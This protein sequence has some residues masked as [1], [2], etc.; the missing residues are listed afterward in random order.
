MPPVGAYVSA[1]SVSS[2]RRTSGSSVSQLRIH[3]RHHSH[4]SFT[5]AD[6]ST[7]AGSAT[8]D[9]YQVMTNGTS[10]PGPTAN[11]A[12]VVRFSPYTGT[13]ESIR[14]ASGP[15]TA[16]RYSRIRRTHGTTWP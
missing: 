3:A 10:S 16:R 13:P 7:G 5:A 15:A 8:C 14:T 1:F 2:E 11:L 12:R 9:G 4:V 6:A